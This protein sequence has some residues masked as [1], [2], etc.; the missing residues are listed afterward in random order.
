MAKVTVNPG[1]CG[2]VS[3]VAVVLGDDGMCTLQGESPCPHVQELLGALGPVDPFGEI[4]YR[5][6]MPRILAKAH[7]TLPHPACPVPA[8]LLKAVEVAASLALPADVSIEVAP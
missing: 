3:S 7:E 6:G 5:T 1:V 8:A 2:F 4:S